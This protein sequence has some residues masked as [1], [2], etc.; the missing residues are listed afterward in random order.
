MA[1]V[2]SLFGSFSRDAP[3]DLK[4]PANLVCLSDDDRV[5]DEGPQDA[6]RDDPSDAPA[7]FSFGAETEDRLVSARH[8]ETTPLSPIEVAAASFEVD[9]TL[10]QLMTGTREQR[11]LS[12]EQVAD[13]THIP[14]YYVRMIESDRYDAIPDQ[15]YL[16]PFFR[17]YAIF[18]GLDEKKVVSRFIRDFERAENEVIETPVPGTKSKAFLM[19]R[20]IALVVL[21]SAV[22][23]PFAARGM[24][25]MRA[26]L[27]HPADGSSSAAISPISLPAS[28][29]QSSDAQQPAE[30]PTTVTSAPAISTA[31]AGPEIDRQPTQAKHQR[32]RARGHRLSRSARHSTAR[33]VTNRTD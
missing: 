16:L 18:L 31:S 11:G 7:Q 1:V 25:I 17:R 8:P 21:V 27:H 4:A 22:L 5:W 3:S 2:R 26:A 19:W 23:L 28:T 14:A 6:V 29:I 15:L 13:Q 12:R 24:G 20:Q 32:R 30:A 10:G 33:N 9:Q